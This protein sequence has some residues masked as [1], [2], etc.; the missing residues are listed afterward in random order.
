MLYNFFKKLFIV[1]AGSIGSGTAPFN[2]RKIVFVG[3]V[4]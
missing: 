1:Y 4:Q 3:I 2:N